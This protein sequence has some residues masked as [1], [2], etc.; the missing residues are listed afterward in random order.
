M[1]H[2]KRFIFLFFCLPGLLLTAQTPIQFVKQQSP[3]SSL[4]K[5][6]HFEN[7]ML[8]Y[9]CGDKG[10]ILKTSDGGNNW[11]LQSAGTNSNLWDVEIAPG[12]GGQQVMVV[13]DNKAIKKSVDGGVHWTHVLSPLLSNTF[14]FGIQA[15]DNQNWWICG[16]EFLSSPG[17]IL[18]T[19]NAGQ[20]WV[21]KTNHSQALFMEKVML[22]SGQI[23]YACGYENNGGGLI[24][25]TV[26]GGN[27]WQL[28]KQTPIIINALWA[29]DPNT[30]IAVSGNGDIWYTEDGGA[31]WEN[32][33][34]GEFYLTAVQFYDKQNGFISGSNG[35][36][37]KVL[38]TID[39]GKTWKDLPFQFGPCEGLFVAQGLLYLVGPDGLIVRGVFPLSGLDAAP[40]PEFALFP[41][42]TSNRLTLKSVKTSM[43]QANLLAMD[44]KTIKTFHLNGNDAQLELPELPSGSYII[45]IMFDDGQQARK[46]IQI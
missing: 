38:Q 26:D 36:A 32:N 14:L 18:K 8:G 29:T 31:N 30:C 24:Y 17:V 27:S 12:T 39:G 13:G 44:G 6:I 23:G 25:K 16:G 34:I 21:K 4:I 15:I 41:N 43:N 42:P 28:S 7:T 40:E 2:T 45:E 46:I 5:A 11:T 1:I 37:G 20:T 33:S 35:E 19:E 22:V 3:V 9:A 10:K